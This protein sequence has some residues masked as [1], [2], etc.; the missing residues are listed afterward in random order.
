MGQHHARELHQDEVVER[1][2][3]PWNS[4]GQQI[5]TSSRTIA[6]SV[7]ELRGALSAIEDPLR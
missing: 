4:V 6:A 5:D 1:E 3:E 7:A 2:Y